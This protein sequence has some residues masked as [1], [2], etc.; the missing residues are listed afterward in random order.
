[1]GNPCETNPP[2][3]SGTT[4]AP[5]ATNIAANAAVTATFS[6]AMRAST[7]DATTFILKDSANS[8]VSGAVTYDTVN[9]IAT[10]RPSSSLSFSTVYAAT[11]TTGVKDGVGNAMVVEHVWSFTTGATTLNTAPASPVLVSPANGQTGLSASVELRWKKST[12]PDGDAVG[13]L[14]YSCT[15]QTFTGCTPVTVASTKAP[16]TYLAGLGASSLVFLAG[17]SIRGRKKAVMFVLLLVIALV[18]AGTVITACGS[19]GGGNNGTPV[20]DE[21]SQTVSAPLAGTTYFWKVV[22]ADGKGGVS[23]SEVWSFTTQ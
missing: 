12:D 14:V 18:I 8:A 2:T 17:L 7:V 6:E 11:I 20:G 1:V 4:P 21:M 5:G 9:K 10:F 23:S 16:N 15:D 22:A 13:Y 3:V 19:G